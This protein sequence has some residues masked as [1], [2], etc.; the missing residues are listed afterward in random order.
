MRLEIAPAAPKDSY[1]VVGENWYTDWRATVDGTPTP[2]FRGDGALITVAVP[3]GAQQVELRFESD[4]YRIGKGIMLGSL[5]LIL[6]GFAGP[7]IGR[8]RRGT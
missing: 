1:V 8:R 3:T 4:A 5:V 6:V 7:I 2:T